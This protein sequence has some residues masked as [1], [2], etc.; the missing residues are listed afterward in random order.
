[1]K[2]D[3]IKPSEPAKSAVMKWDDIQPTGEQNTRQKR[4]PLQMLG[5][6]AGLIARSL[7]KGPLDVADFVTTP[8]RESLN[9]IPGVNI[10]TGALQRDI[11][12][13]LGL[14]EPESTSE[15][16]LS[17]GAEMAAGAGG[18]MKGAQI[19]SGAL[20]SYAI[21]TK[22]VLSTMAANPFLQ[23]TSAASAGVA[24]EYVKEKGGKPTQQL[25]ASI[26][27]GVLVPTS[28]KGAAS[29]LSPKASTNPQLQA[30]RAEGVKPTIGQAMGGRAAIAE[31]KLQS[32]PILGD[33]IHRAR[34]QTLE[35]FNKAAINRA[36]EPIGKKVDGV[37]HAAIKEAG[38]ALSK[39]YDDAL[40]QV[41]NVRFDAKFDADTMQLRQMASGLSTEMRRK[42]ERIL[43]ETVIRKMSPQRSMM[44]DAYK[45]VDSE[46]GLVASRYG[47]SSVASEQ[48]LG[49]ALSQ[50]QAL[51]KEQMMR[52]NPQIAAKLKA[53]D[54]GW[55]NLV[56]IEGAAKA[57]KNA[58][59]IFTPA[60]L[61]AAI[62][63]ADT[64]VRGRA[65]SRG[66]ALMQD[67]GIGGQK[68]LG[69]K[70]PD[71][72]T[73][74]RLAMGGAAVGAGV[75]NPLIPASLAVGGSL[76]TRPVQNA[77]VS[78][79]ADRP[80]AAQ[81]LARQLRGASGN[82]LARSPAWM[83]PAASAVSE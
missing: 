65:V 64:S 57:A 10:P 77:L 82:A 8:L 21:K 73:A 79:L 56:R 4:N 46:I 36:L 22:D 67:L 58:E 7:I 74:G 47:K 42:F 54:T 12:E 45:A 2:W 25:A 52:S 43:N 59:G 20:P 6:D 72:G 80:E 18:F 32:V 1:M 40:G 26:A 61:N 50:L 17:K 41:K 30:L 35:S 62:Q 31:E 24:G 15:K 38:D 5:R 37:G 81:L 66:T 78:M 70:Y 11:P 71:S 39:T 19:V 23:M 60:Q 68:V 49:D 48:E 29:V 9:L 63:S 14:P 33:M 3:D 83:L 76:Y 27:G 13:A 69:S 44:G 51:L 55:A 75:Y 16:V 53:A 34:G 28:L